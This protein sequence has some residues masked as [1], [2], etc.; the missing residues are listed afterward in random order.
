MKRLQ[1]AVVRLRRALEPSDGPDAPRLRPVSGGYVL[2]VAPGELDAELF[3]ERMRDGRRALADGDPAHAT[4]LLVQALGLWRGPA[5]ADVAFQDL[6]SRDPSA[7]GVA[8]GCTRISDRC[9]PS[10]RRSRRADCRARSPPRPTADPRTPRRP[11]HDSAVPL[12]PPS[13]R[14][15]GLPTHPHAALRTA[16]SCTGTSTHRAAD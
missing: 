8:P 2:A 6:P 13:R 7:R 9:R 16:R 14:A 1:M 12:R 15:R 11:A 10:I 4:G 5:L 3:A